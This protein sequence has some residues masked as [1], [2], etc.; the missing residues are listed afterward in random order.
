MLP[1]SPVFTFCGTGSSKNKL[2][3][4]RKSLHLGRFYLQHVSW[5]CGRPSKIQGDRK[6]HI[7]RY[8]FS[9]F[10][11]NATSFSER[12]LTQNISYKT[13]SV[14]WFDVVVAKRWRMTTCFQTN[15]SAKIRDLHLQPTPWHVLCCASVK[16]GSN[17]T[18]L[19]R[20]I[21]GANCVGVERRSRAPWHRDELR[22]DCHRA[23]AQ[24]TSTKPGR[25]GNRWQRQFVSESHNC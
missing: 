23:T 3:L 12:P 16:I 11:E 17:P 6:L 4:Q 2:H 14:S 21:T 20:F 10:R 8:Q 19:R 24:L 18:E 25:P 1:F 7:G 9:R 5:H 13:Q 22:D 15:W